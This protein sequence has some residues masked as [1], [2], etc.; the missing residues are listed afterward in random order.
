LVSIA[1]Y[2]RW[3]RKGLGRAVLHLDNHRSEPYR[4]TILNAC[5]SNWNYDRQCE[6]S[7]AQFMFDLI[8]RTGEAE[9][10][11]AEIV[12]AMTAQDKDRVSQ[13]CEILQLLAEQGDSKARESL[14]QWFAMCDVNE[15]ANGR[16]L[17][18]LDGLEGFLFVANRIGSVDPAEYDPWVCSSLFSDLAEQIG[19]EAVWDALAVNAIANSNIERFVN[20]LHEYEAELSKR[21]RR[22]AAGMAGLSYDEIKPRLLTNKASGIPQWGEQ[23]SDADILSAAED[24]LELSE[25]WHL[26]AYLRIFRA[27]RFP[28]DAGHLIRLAGHSNVQVAVFALAA[29]SNINSRSAREFALELMRSR[30]LLRVKGIQALAGSFEEGDH[31]L[32]EMFALQNLSATQFHD[33]DFVVEKYYKAHS[34]PQSEIR[35]LLRLYE[36]SPCLNCRAKA[37][38]RLIELDALPDWMRAECEWDAN[39]ETR[40]LVKGVTK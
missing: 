29:L 6:P 16:T 5:L 1:E 15:F 10:Y 37:V 22:D 34:N 31:E 9:F 20:A 18:A 19:K 25:N 30:S 17:I 38:R 36:T 7:R 8:Q 40:L 11:Q 4:Q 35:I 12:A 26:R 32:I 21:D 3:L 24:L 33:L 28:L 14:Y 27:R 2:R 13:L 23:A 39:P